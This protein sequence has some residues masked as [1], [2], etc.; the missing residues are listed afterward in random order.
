M[1]QSVLNRKLNDIGCERNLLEKRGPTH[2]NNGGKERYFIYGEE[3][4]C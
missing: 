3:I 4:I 2:Y 1:K